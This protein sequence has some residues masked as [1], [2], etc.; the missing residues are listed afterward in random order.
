MTEEEIRD[1]FAYHSPN[2]EMVSRHEHI[3]ARM[4][5]LVLEIAALLPPS[6]ERMLFIRGMQQA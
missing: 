5:E 6:A 3:R 2:P 4:T 1:I